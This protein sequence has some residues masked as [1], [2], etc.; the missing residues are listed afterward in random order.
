MH[1]FSGAKGGG[2]GSSFKQRPDTLRSTD[3]VEGLLGLCAGPIKGLTRGL[4]SLKI[5]GTPLEDESGKLNFE[6]F[7]AVLADGDPT[8]FPQQVDLR[9]GAG[10]SP[11]GVNLAL[12]NTNASGPGPWITKSVANL[13][14]DFLD[15]RFL[16]NQLYR[17]RKSGIS[18]IGK[19]S[20]RESWGKNV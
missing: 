16:V 18:D 8:A 5:D 1:G 10:G 19:A 14:A 2:S 15:F 17:D 11:V 4:K 9:L 3:T 20:G 13:N 6:N 12:S 7:V